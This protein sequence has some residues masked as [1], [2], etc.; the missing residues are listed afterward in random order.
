MLAQVGA[1]AFVADSHSRV[2]CAF[3]VSIPWTLRVTPL[4]K[5]N[6][7]WCWLINMPQQNVYTDTQCWAEFIF[8]VALARCIF[9]LFALVNCRLPL[10]APSLLLLYIRMLVTAYIP[11]G[12][13]CT[14]VRCVPRYVIITNFMLGKHNLLPAHRQPT[15]KGKVPRGTRMGWAGETLQMYEHH[16]L[17]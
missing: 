8:V 12:H 14:S 10:S 2:A 17:I 7:I 6:Y 5:F 13:I 1:T 9:I 11:T 4:R 15:D 16:R 3:V